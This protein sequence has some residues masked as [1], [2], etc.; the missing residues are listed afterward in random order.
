MST[1]KLYVLT[2][3]DFHLPRHASGGIV[4][5]DP[6][7]NLPQLLWP[8]GTVCWLA[9]L[10][11]LQGYRRG[12]SRRNRGGTLVTWAKHLS[13]L[14][15]WCFRNAINFHDMWDSHFVMFVRTL[16]VEKSSKNLRS[17]KRS[18][19]QVN[20]IC[21]TILNFL[22]FVDSQM[23]GLNLIGPTGRIRAEK[24]T[25]R[26]TA[27]HAER[28]IERT[29]W[30]HEEVPEDRHCRRRFPVSSSAVERLY[31]ANDELEAELFVK[32]RRYI[33]LRLLEITGGRRIEV[34]MIKEQDIEDALLTGKLK[35][36]TAKKRKE[37][38]RVVPV[39][40]TDL[41]DILSY[42]KHYRKRIVRAT[43]GAARDSGFLLIS[44]TS[45]TPLAVDTLSSEM[46]TLRIAA[47]ID[48][49]EV[50]LHAFR[51]RFATKVLIQL[52]LSRRYETEDDL[53][54][55]ILDTETLK[56][57]LMEWLGVSSLAMVNHYV[58]LAFEELADHKGTLNRL[59]IYKVA[60]AMEAKS[61][62]LDR[63]FASIPTSDLRREL[64]EMMDS[65]SAAALELRTALKG[66]HSKQPS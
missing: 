50:C 65:S 3:E 13:H 18:F 44:S 30:F 26:I 54:K 22:A 66:T 37:A 43:V 14:I 60:D 42:C 58:H 27:R 17:K 4:S 25:Y 9:N 32:R 2:T 24:R 45:G 11:L 21:S 16:K 56:L 59:Q 20:T 38:S 1:S 28:T 57:Q 63:R 19:A 5:T 34:S 47:G 51:H 48:D 31:L 35:L 23:P 62:D 39:S 52:I 41:K 61:E 40:R 12:R 8:D 7:G 46:R 33:M 29:Y 64:R 10:Y 55:A 53:K 15:R 36:F 6:A 49:E